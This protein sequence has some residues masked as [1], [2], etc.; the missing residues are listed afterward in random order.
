MSEE[1]TETT[2]EKARNNVRAFCLRTFCNLRELDYFLCE[3]FC[4]TFF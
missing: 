4:N 2:N 3:H 1:I